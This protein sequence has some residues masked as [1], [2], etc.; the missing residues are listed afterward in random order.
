MNAIVRR[1]EVFELESLP[2]PEQ[3]ELAD[4]VRAGGLSDPILRGDYDGRLLVVLGFIPPTILAEDAYLWMYTS[5]HARQFPYVV[6]RWG[7]RVVEAAFHRYTR[8]VGHCNRDSAHWL[9]RLGAEV[10]P[11]PGGL[12]FKLEAGNVTRG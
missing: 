1:V 4:I 6:G 9:R 12:T 2:I 8:I 11:G 5:E 10:M 3:D 7:F